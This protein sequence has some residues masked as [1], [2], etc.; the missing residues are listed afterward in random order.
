MC[1]SALPSYGNVNL[2]ERLVEVYGEPRPTGYRKVTTYAL[3][4]MLSPRVAGDMPLDVIE[5]LGTQAD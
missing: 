3:C 5:I 2:L 1:R 4:Q